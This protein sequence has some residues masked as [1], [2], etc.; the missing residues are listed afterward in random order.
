M[1]TLT[2]A[3]GSRASKGA[4]G[5]LEVTV[6]VLAVNCGVF[7]GGCCCIEL[8]IELTAE[9]E[10]APIIHSEQVEQALIVN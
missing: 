1:V 6:A 8:S 10:D 3:A 7:S 2:R 4:N 5:F 9:A